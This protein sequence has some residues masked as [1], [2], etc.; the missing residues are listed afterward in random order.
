MGT[1]VT[2]SSPALRKVPALPPLHLQ[3]TGFTSFQKLHLN[4]RTSLG[5]QTL[6][7]QCGVPDESPPPVAFNGF[8]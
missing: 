1:K 3:Q 2:Y 7:P 8:S 6:Q 5:E 4:T